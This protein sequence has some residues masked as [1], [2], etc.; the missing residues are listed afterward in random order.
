MDITGRR[1]PRRLTLATFAALASLVWASSALGAAPPDVLPASVGTTGTPPSFTI[2]APA[3]SDPLATIDWSLGGPSPQP[4]GS[5]LGAA[6]PL[7]T[8]P[9]G[10]IDGTYTLTANH[11]IPPLVPGGPP[12]VGTTAV[13]F[14]LDTVALPPTITS[15]IPAGNAN[16]ATFTWMGEG[17]TFTCRLTGPTGFLPLDCSAG[18]GPVPLSTGTYQFFVSTTDS[19]GH[20]SSE[21]ATPPFAVDTVAP[22]GGA[23]A[24]APA[25]GQVANFTNTALVNINLI[26]SSADDVS[27]PGAITYALTTAS[28]PQPTTGFSPW[29]PQMP[30]VSQIAQ[31]TVF[32]WAQ[33]AAGNISPAPV[34][35]TLPITFDNQPPTVV[36]NP[37][38]LPQP[39]A[40]LTTAFGPL[41]NIQIQFSE[42][43]QNP[44][45]FIR[46]CINLCGL[47]VPATVTYNT[48]TGVAILDPFGT[49]STG[50]FAATQYEIEFSPPT[51]PSNIRDFA[52]NRLTGAGVGN[53]LWTF[54]TSSDATPPGPV[55]GLLAAPGIQRVVLNWAPPT[56]PDLARIT[57]LRGTSPPAAAGDAT[58]ARFSLPAGARSF[59]DVG[60]TPLVPYHYAVYAEDAVGNPSVLARAVAVARAPVVT[61]GLACAKPPNT[62]SARLMRPKKGKVLGT[63]R[64]LMRWKG[65]KTAVLYN[66]QFE[67]LNIKSKR[68]IL[69]GF[70]RKAAYK[71]PKNRLKPGHCYAWRVWAYRGRAR[72][73]VKIPMTSWFDTSPRA[74]P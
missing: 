66:I 3:L 30:S 26:T 2:S 19:L 12:D 18:L 33:D 5:G 59:T 31:T 34:A 21:A 4:G 68:K 44:V 43:V 45:P 62:I 11:T 23:I 63:L 51:G 56:D 48:S 1:L 38:F 42:L 10:G 72:G 13:I 50:L 65:K 53:A 52:G 57:V 46:T 71:V 73:Y 41:A 16:S 35:S 49:S 40:N 39:G 15:P 27:L 7:N 69:S 25:P 24:H 17:P 67:D 8:G 14:T 60:L 29:P 58:A 55:T 22:V 47:A 70:P 20:V 36:A 28:A 6:G 54:T 32:L 64:P 61:T 9:L 74:R 37:L